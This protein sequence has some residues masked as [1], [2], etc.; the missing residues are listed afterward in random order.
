MFPAGQRG[1][2]RHLLPHAEADDAHIRGPEPFGERRY[3]RR[4]NVPPLSRTIELRLAQDCS[5]S[6]PLPA[7]SLLHDWLCT[8]YLA[9]LAAV[10]RLDRAGA[11]AADVR[12]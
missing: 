1:F 4:H 6:H 7:P 12:C 3:E 2:V 8:S 5:E 11:D 9:G 10:P